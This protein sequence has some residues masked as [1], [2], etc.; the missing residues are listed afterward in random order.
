MVPGALRD[1]EGFFRLA[2]NTG[3]LIN[4]VDPGSPAATAGLRGGDIVLAINEVK[5]DG[6]FPEQL[7]PIQHQIASLPVNSEVQ[8]LVKRA[9]ETFTVTAVTEELLSRVGE[10]RLLTAW[11]L[12]VRD[13]SRTYARENQFPDEAGVLV[14]G[15][16][17]GFPGEVAGL[18]RGDVI[19]SINREP[20]KDLADAVDAAAQFTAKPAP[21]L[22]EARRN[23]RISLYVLKP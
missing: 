6:R 12:S 5:I 21:T 10:E 22:V 1:L 9:D 3:M 2:L 15:V 7:P 8:L 4:S 13:V 19:T 17:R 23:F 18:S 14:I 11:G 16:Q 20:I